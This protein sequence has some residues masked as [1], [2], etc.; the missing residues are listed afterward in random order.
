MWRIEFTAVGTPRTKGSTSSF[1]SKRTGRVVTHDAAGTPGLTWEQGVASA[2][3]VAREQ[4][5]LRIMQGAPIGVSCVFYQ[6]RLRGHYGT[7]RNANVLKVGAPAYPAKKP[8]VDKYLRRILDALTGV[9][10]GDDGQVV[11]VAGAK[12]WGDPARAEIRVWAV[13]AVAEDGQLGL[14]LDDQLALAVA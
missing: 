13:G 4:A 12:R 8:D 10:Y 7:G 3:L 11:L 1:I 6:P 2:A 14:G 5:G 9:A